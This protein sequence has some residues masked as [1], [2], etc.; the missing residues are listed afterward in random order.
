MDDLIQQIKLQNEEIQKLK[1][2]KT[3]KANEPGNKLQ[4]NITNWLEQKEQD[5]SDTLQ[6]LVQKYQIKVDPELMSTLTSDCLVFLMELNEEI[7][8]KVM[9]NPQN[10]PR[11]M[12]VKSNFVQRMSQSLVQFKMLKKQNEFIFDENNAEILNILNRYEEI[13]QNNLSSK[14]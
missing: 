12:I 3:F 9:A 14:T 5:K 8:E 4:Q 7:Q 10:D 11:I 6:N 1:E 2:E 13:R